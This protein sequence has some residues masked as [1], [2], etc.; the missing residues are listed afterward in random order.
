MGRVYLTAVN[1][2]VK[3]ARN[4]NVSGQKLLSA[5]SKNAIRADNSISADIISSDIPQC[6]IITNGLIYQFR[7]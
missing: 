5:G 2:Q 3:V 7:Q 4:E 6:R 1:P